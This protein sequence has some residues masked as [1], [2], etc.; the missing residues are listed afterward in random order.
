MDVKTAYLNAPIDCEI[1]M[2]Q[3]EGFETPNSD[4]NERLVYKLNKSLYGLK[5]SGRN[6]NMLLHKC[7]IENN[8]T[9]SSVDH[10]VYRKEVGE[11]KVF[12]LIWVDDI[13]LAASDNE[14]MNET[15]MMLQER[16]KMKDLGK[17][18]YFLGI[19]F[20]QGDGF[21]KMSQKRYLSKVLERFHMSN[22]KPRNT[23]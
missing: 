5:Q 17:L 18:S 4:E 7:L 2:E 12:V 16:F 19:E 21:V 9:Q 3:A 20:E 11:K 1:Y 23:P 10:C 22:C 6:W 14:I 15:K 13:I 8:F